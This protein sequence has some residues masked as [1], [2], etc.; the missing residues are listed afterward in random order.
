MRNSSDD[1]DNLIN[2]VLNER[3]KRG[4]TQYD[5]S[6]SMQKVYG[7]PFS[8]TLVS[9][10]EGKQLTNRSVKKYFPL[11]KK[12]MDLIQMDGF[13]PNVVEESKAPVR[14]SRRGATKASSKA[15]GGTPFTPRVKI[16]DSVK[17]VDSAASNKRKAEVPVKTPSVS[18][19]KRFSH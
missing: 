10:F 17:Q 19:R 7:R 11:F 8:Q 15:A 18:S 1:V 13:D 2:E 3:K 5:L 6:T 4:F 16:G 12:W 9:R 14:R